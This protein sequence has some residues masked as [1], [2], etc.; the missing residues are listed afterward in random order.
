MNFT[1]AYLYASAITLIFLFGM[2][3]SKGGANLLA[4][5]FLLVLGVAGIVIAVKG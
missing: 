5:L 3:S 2:W 1:T 4:K